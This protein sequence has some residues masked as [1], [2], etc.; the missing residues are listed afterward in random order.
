MIQFEGQPDWRT[1][2]EFANTGQIFSA[3]PGFAWNKGIMTLLGMPRLSRAGFSNK[4][5]QPS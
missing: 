2:K 4:E 1:M 3:R 5:K